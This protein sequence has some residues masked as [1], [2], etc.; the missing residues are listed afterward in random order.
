MRKRP[1]WFINYMAM[2]G[3][4]YRQLEGRETLKIKLNHLPY[5][6]KRHQ[7]IGWRE[8]IKNLLQIKLP[9]IGAKN[10]YLALRKLEEINV[11]APQVKLFAQSG[12]NPA[13]QSSLIIM[14]AI[15]NAVSLEDF[16]RNWKES[17]PDYHMKR[18]L[19]MHVAEMARKMHAA[20]MNHRDLYICH[21]LLKTNSLSERKLQI[22]LIDLHRAQCRS[23]VPKRWLIKDLSG[24]YFSIMN[25]GLSKRDIYYFLRQYFQMNLKDIFSKHAE[26]LRKVDKKALKLYRREN[27]GA[28]NSFKDLATSG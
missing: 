8:I 25:I 14:E 3:D 1:Q 17:P 20:G 13:K 9:V 23:A 11:L 7:G 19:I 10:E 27:K 18:R 21:F 15:E 22:Y 28:N 4:V 5:F 2:T 6:L 26:L 24:L 16:C 12:M